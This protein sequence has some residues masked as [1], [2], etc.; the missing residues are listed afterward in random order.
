MTLLLDIAKGAVPVAVI[1]SLT[2]CGAFPGGHAWCAVTVAVAAVLGHMFTA[3]AGFKGGKGV[4]TT[5]GVLLAL[6]PWAF[7]VFVTVFL[8]TLLATRYVS[9]GSVLGAI[10]F[11]VSLAWL[12]PGGWRD[13]VFA[14][15][16][17]LAILVIA[18]HRENLQRLARGEERRFSFGGGKP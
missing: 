15:G 3:F 1:P 11:S 18:R 10:A 5:V 16:V 13:P 9:L 2:A 14:L 17:A 4:A 8:V 7:L 6:C 12:A